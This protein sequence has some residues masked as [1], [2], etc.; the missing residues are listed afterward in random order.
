MVD[1]VTGSGPVQNILSSSKT[2]AKNERPVQEKAAPASGD[3]VQISA[4]AQ[5][6]LSVAQAE[7]AAKD[8]SSA[9]QEDL[10]RV[11]GIDP[12]FAEQAISDL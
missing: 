12:T 5:E 4:E 1:P 7:Q 10:N 9:L 2:Q 6:L 8:I 11:L 3:Q